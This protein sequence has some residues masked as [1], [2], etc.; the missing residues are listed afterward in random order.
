M[1]I[2][3]KYLYSLY[4]FKLD[5]CTIEEVVKIEYAYIPIYCV[6]Y[7]YIYIFRVEHVSVVYYLYLYN[8][9]DRS[10]R[11]VIGVPFVYTLLNRSIDSP[12]MYYKIYH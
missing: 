3:K 4:N 6:L 9:I 12:K 2:K 7:I 11:N 8:V 10:R 1:I 5:Q